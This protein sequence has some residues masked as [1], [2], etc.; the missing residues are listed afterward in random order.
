V[1][2]EEIAAMKAENEK[3][4]KDLEEASK[5]K[6]T[7]NPPP[8]KPEEEDGL[9]EKAEKERKEKEAAA[10][11]G[12]Q[13]ERS[14][15][16]NLTVDNF[17]KENKDL[18]PKNVEGI[19]SSAAKE[20]YDSETQKANAQ[21]V[22]IALEFF[23]LQENVDL[24]TSSQKSALEEFQKLTKNSKEERAEEI[25]N[26]LFEPALETLKKVRKAS[27]LAKSK[28]GKADTAGEKAYI[29]RLIKHSRK[30]LLGEK[31]SA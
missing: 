22:A 31:E 10:S 16:F 12:K 19:L 20:N 18:L 1:T 14:I 7:P 27:E 5:K 23:S 11:K 4:K 8:A 6:E 30:A 2:P 9:K 15:K 13:V 24:L 25:Y 28:N 26:N 3:L 29:D 17:V 21:R